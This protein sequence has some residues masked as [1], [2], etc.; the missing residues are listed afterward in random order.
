MHDDKRVPR[1]GEGHP[2]DS[3]RH[4][5]VQ[6]AGVSIRVVDVALVDDGVARQA[7]RER[8]RVI[9]LVGSVVFDCVASTP[10][11]TTTKQSN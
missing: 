4:A 8:R 2:T 7:D 1:S 11:C 3:T 10:R 6:G 9:G 5:V